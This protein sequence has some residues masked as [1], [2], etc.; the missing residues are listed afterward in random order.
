MAEGEDW[1][2]Q[3]VLANLIRYESLRDGSV[4]ILDVAICIDALETRAENE[5]R[6]VKVTA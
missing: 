3:P 1:I 2:M 5:R 6:S 4:D